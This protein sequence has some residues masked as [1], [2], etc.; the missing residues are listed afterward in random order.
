MKF[1]LFDHF[2]LIF[3]NLIC[4]SSDISKYF[5]E[6]L[7]FEIMRVDC[8]SDNISDLSAFLWIQVWTAADNVFGGVFGELTD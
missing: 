8:I 1:G 2:L 6:A 5:R 4:R 3:A 7:V